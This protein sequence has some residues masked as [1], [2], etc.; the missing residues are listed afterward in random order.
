MY[1]LYNCENY[2]LKP[3]TRFQQNRPSYL[4]P[5]SNTIV[6]FKATANKGVEMP[7]FY[8][9]ALSAAQQTQIP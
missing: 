8:E 1:N 3:N 2:K 7:S 9:A 6:H 5:S 4:T